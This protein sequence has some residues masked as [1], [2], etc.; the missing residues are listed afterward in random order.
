ALRAAYHAGTVPPDADVLVTDTRADDELYCGEGTVASVVQAWEEAPLDFVDK[1]EVK[2]MVKEFSF[3]E[4]Q[5]ESKAQFAD[6]KRLYDRC[7]KYYRHVASDRNLKRVTKETTASLVLTLDESDPMRDA[8]DGEKLFI[9]ELRRRHPELIRSEDEKQPKKRRRQKQK[10]EREARRPLIETR[11]NL[12]NF[13]H[14]EMPL[15]VKD[16]GTV[17]VRDIVCS[18][19]GQKAD[20]WAWM[21]RPLSPTAPFRSQRSRAPHFPQMN[22]PSCPR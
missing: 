17:R 21:S 2:R 1:Q 3:P 6:L 9:E 20:R 4:Y 19:R 14:R 13:P 10:L 12:T 11:N 15:D 7:Y 16:I 22:A 5:V 18:S 8:S